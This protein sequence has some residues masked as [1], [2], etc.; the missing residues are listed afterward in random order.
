MPPASESAYNSRLDGL[1]ALAVFA[2]LYT[3]LWNENS[4]AGDLGV[5]LFFVLSGYLITRM[6]I[7]AKTGGSTRLTNFYVRRALRLWPAYYALIAFCTATNFGMFR[8]VALWH[9]LYLSN[10][11]FALR[12]A[13]VPFYTAAWWSLAVEEQFYLVWPAI[14]MRVSHRAALVLCVLAIPAALAFR[15][16][17]HHNGWAEQAYSLI[18]ASIDGLGAGAILALC[19]QRGWSWRANGAILLVWMVVM[20]CIVASGME[21]YAWLPTFEVVGLAGVVAVAITGFGGAVD[22]ILANGVLVY[23]GRISY[24]IYLFHLFVW[25]ILLR[26]FGF[27]LFGQ[28]GFLLFVICGGLTIIMAS[29]SWFLV[30]IPFNRLKRHF[31]FPPPSG[32]GPVPLASARAAY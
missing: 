16:V 9:A 22:R 7:A 12:G 10:F 19:E 5:R 21:Q 1:R 11:L 3:H 26:F 30:E 20:A 8:S 29:L 17:G 13:Y 32:S 23:L 14:V 28:R 2:V 27:A 25:A 6:V 24:G 31:P 4:L 15:V 18:P